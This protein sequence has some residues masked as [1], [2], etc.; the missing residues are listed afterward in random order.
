MFNCQNDEDQDSQKNEDISDHMILY[1]SNNQAWHCL[2]G[3]SSIG[4]GSMGF[5]RA[6]AGAKVKFH[7]HLREAFLGKSATPVVKLHPVFPKK[8]V[9]NKNCF[10]RSLLGN[11]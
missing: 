4:T 8:Y 9:L 1:A 6:L 3:A 2:G 7:N 10:I 11:H 5:C